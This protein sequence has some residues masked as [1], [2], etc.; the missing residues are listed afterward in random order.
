MRLKSS[1]FV[2]AALAAFV[3]FSSCDVW[4]GQG[5]ENTSV[6]MDS[7]V[8]RPIAAFQRDLLE[9][10][11]ATA[12]A[13][14]VRPHLKD[15]SRAQEAVVAVSLELGQPQRAQHYIKQI[16]NWRRGAGYADLA[17]YYAQHG[18]TNE[19]QH[20]LK[21]ASQ[22]TRDPKVGDW[23]RDRI[24]VKIAKAHLWL[25]QTRQADQV[26]AGV[27]QSESGKVARV[28]ATLSDKNS[29]T[30]Q[31]KAL[32]ALIGSG[33]L[34][35]IKNALDAYAALFDRFYDDA[36]RRS[37]VEEKLK[38]GLSNL[39]V[40][41]RIN[42]LL[43]LAK[44]ALEHADPAQALQLVNEAQTMTDGHQW[45]PRYGIP[46]KAQLAG[47]RFRVGDTPKARTDADAALA[48]FDAVRHQMVDIDRAETIR[49]LAETYQS[50]GDTAAALALYKRVVEEGVQNPN[51]RP[52]AEELSA[53]CRSMALHGVEPDAQLWSRMH[54]IRQGLGPPW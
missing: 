7:L 40:L 9:L 44:S 2:L 18:Q 41:F 52:H 19:A 27:V 28:K 3:Y 8:D 25:G 50:M 13:I 11:F 6:Q 49:P 20:Y 4:A 5:S 21:L 15:R 39:P 23:R 46:L 33:H 32:D 30:E 17:F 36:E 22:S 37:Q 48:L 14:P 43:T 51:S 26:A 35:V 38:T 10:A 53:T 47:L 45:P 31:I 42:L 12:T 16:D 34:D 24:R 29:F 54:Q 1:V